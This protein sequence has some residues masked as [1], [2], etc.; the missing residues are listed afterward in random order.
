MKNQPLSDTRS[1][2]SSVWI[3]LAV[4]LLFGALIAVGTMAIINANLNLQ[5]QEP[6]GAQPAPP[7]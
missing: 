1:A 5:T 3:I 7:R 2:D 4:L 6:T